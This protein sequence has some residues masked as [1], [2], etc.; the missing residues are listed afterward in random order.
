[1]NKCIMLAV[2][3]IRKKNNCTTLADFV[4]IRNKNK[5]IM[6]AV[7]SIKKR[8]NVLYWQLLLR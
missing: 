5:C 2:V 1:M 6:L 4:N 3:K 8:V 7:I